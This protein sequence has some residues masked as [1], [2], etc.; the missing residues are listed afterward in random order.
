MIVRVLCACLPLRLIL[1]V[2]LIGPIAGLGTIPSQMTAL[3]IQSR[4]ETTVPGR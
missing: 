2:I 1:T 4:S 3:Q